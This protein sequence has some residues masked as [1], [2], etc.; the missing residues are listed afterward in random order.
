MMRPIDTIRVALTALTRNKVRSFLT[1][2]GVIIGVAAVI[3]MLA[4]GEG[5][6]KRVEQTFTSM[7]SNLLII[8]SGSSMRGGTRGGAGS[9]PS[10]TWDDMEAIGEEIPLATKISPVLRGSGQAISKHFNWQTSVYGISPDYLAIRSWGVVEGVALEDHD[11]RSASANVLVGETV[12]RE[13]FGEGLDVI[14][15]TIRINGT[16]FTIIGVLAPKGQSAW[17]TD[18]DDT[19]LMPYTTYQRRIQSSLN[20]FIDGS[21]HVSTDESSHL[22]AVMAQ[23]RELLRTRHRLRQGA[24]DDFQIR[25]LTEMAEAQEEGTRTFTTLLAAIAAVSLL[26][27]GIGIMNIMLVSVTERTREIGLRMAVGARP[28]DILL[29]FLLEALCLSL[30]GGLIGA[31]LGIGLA[32]KLGE[33]FG[34]T[35]I[36]HPSITLISVG[37]SAFV[38][39]VFGLHPALQASRL[40]PIEALRYE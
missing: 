37:F 27:G 25:N 24:P 35:V 30:L 39:I 16:P 11:V 36:I 2:L 23:T 19:V 14:G 12:R 31:G 9:E 1:T 15:E 22:E 34:W 5:A 18:N 33:S 20:R 4:I 21:L 32:L 3:S 26:V 40:D 7:G 28:R 8:S 38:G 17:G 13:L 10:L 29:Q 6:R